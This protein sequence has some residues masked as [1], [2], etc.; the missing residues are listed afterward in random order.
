MTVHLTAK[1]TER[2]RADQI[3]LPFRRCALT[4]M[5]HREAAIVAYGQFRKQVGK[6]PS[7]RATAAPPP[8]LGLGL[9]FKPSALCGLK[10]LLGNDFREIVADWR[11]LR[12]PFVAID[13]AGL[14]RPTR[15]RPPQ[16]IVDCRLL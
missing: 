7:F 13:F 2:I 16:A 4:L 12:P 9:P 3:R 5:V 14:K 11:A 10:N 15:S 6:I 1:I 8:S